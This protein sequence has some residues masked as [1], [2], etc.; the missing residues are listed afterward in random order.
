MIKK[1]DGRDVEIAIWRRPR[2]RR[3]RRGQDIHCGDFGDDQKYSNSSSF[4]NGRSLG[5]RCCDHAARDDEA[6]QGSHQKSLIDV[7]RPRKI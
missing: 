7:F 1:E 6:I 5:S 4:G 2:L 3:R